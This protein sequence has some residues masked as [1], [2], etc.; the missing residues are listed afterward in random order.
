MPIELIMVAF[1]VA[2]SRSWPLLGHVLLIA[3]IYKCLRE[4][5]VGRPRRKGRRAQHEAAAQR[6]GAAG[7]AGN[8]I[9]AA[10]AAK[11]PEAGVER[12][13]C[14]GRSTIW[15]PARYGEPSITAGAR[16]VTAAEIHR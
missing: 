8:L 14:G 4:D 15:A 1:V 12:A 9:E 16:H 11:S 10:Q 13:G 5:H 3:A 7:G 2:L 6:R